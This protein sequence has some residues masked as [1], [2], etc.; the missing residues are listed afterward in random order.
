MDVV[1]TIGRSCNIED[2]WELRMSL[3]SLSFLTDIGNVFIVGHKPEWCKNVIHIPHED[4][5]KSNKDGN[6]I[7][8][9]ISACFHPD[10][11]EEFLWFSDDQYVLA[12]PAPE[13]L[14]EPV[15]NNGMHH[16]RSKSKWHRR[17][18]STIKILQSRNL[19]TNV[20]ECHVPY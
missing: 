4:P 7:N 16:P 12:K 1:Y 15:H 2:Y 20:Y 11:S 8:K 13:D 14:R 9:L 10:L 18:N 19:T 3:R 17:L 5:Y 6:L